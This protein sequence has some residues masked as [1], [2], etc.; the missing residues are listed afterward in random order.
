M[1]DLQTCLFSLG[2]MVVVIGCVVLFIRFSPEHKA[3]EKQLFEQALLERNEA[4]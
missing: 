4:V 1:P 2:I 3:R